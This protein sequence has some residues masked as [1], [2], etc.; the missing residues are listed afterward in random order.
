MIVVWRQCNNCLMES[1]YLC[2]FFDNSELKQQTVP[3]F[4]VFS[5]SLSGELIHSFIHSIVIYTT[6]EMSI[7]NKFDMIIHEI[8]V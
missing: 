6:T 4:Q 8:F 3:A 2:S 7:L 5:C 1:E